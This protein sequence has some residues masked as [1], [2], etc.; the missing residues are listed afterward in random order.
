MIDKGVNKSFFMYTGPPS[1][2]GNLDLN[3]TSTTVT[4]TWTCPAVG[5][6][7]NLYYTVCHRGSHIVTALPVLTLLAMDA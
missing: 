5:G 4:V 6:L 7:M 1:P 2:P 3:A